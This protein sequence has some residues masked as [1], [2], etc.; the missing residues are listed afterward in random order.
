VPCAAL[1]ERVLEA[2]NRLTAAS[3]QWGRR[4]PRSTTL[5]ARDIELLVALDE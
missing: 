1:E 4:E 5:G 3:I 2:G